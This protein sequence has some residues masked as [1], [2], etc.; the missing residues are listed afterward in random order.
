[1]SGES[2]APIPTPLELA[3]ELLRSSDPGRWKAKREPTSLTMACRKPSRIDGGGCPFGAPNPSL[4]PQD[5][6][7][8]LLRA[9]RMFHHR[10]RADRHCMNRTA[11]NGPASAPAALAKRFLFVGTKEAGSEVIALEAAAAGAPNVNQRWLGGMLPTGTTMRARIDRLKDL[12]RMEIV[13]AIAC[14]PK[15]EAVAARN[16]SLQK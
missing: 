15:K 16:W 9:Q 2:G 6:A 3:I 12:E 8:H 1:V 14:R 4:E 13:C 5:V 7:L 11:S 10:S